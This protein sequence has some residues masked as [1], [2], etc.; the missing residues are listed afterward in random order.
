MVRRTSANRF[1]RAGEETDYAETQGPGVL[2]PE[3]QMGLEDNPENNLE[4][5]EKYISAEE[6]SNNFYPH[7]L[8][9]RR[10]FQDI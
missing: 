9:G 8:M 10:E 5:V 1:Y 2:T 7:A 4:S 3:E 6:P